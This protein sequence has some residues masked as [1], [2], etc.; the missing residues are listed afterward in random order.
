M[1]EEAEVEEDLA[2]VVEETSGAKCIGLLVL[3]VVGTVKFRLDQET[4]GLSIAAIVLK[5]GEMRTV[6]VEGR[7]TETFPDQII[8]KTDLIQKIVTEEI[9]VVQIQGNCQMS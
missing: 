8:A 1:I 4:T 6:E 7:E 9:P 2:A 3:S 5:K